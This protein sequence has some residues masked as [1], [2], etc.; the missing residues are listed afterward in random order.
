MP[1]WRRQR[2]GLTL[3]EAIL[4]TALLGTILVSALLTTGRLRR[5]RWFAERR[6]E[7][8]EIADR[9]LAGWWADRD[10]FPRAASGE[11][12]DRPGWR[13][14]TSVRPSEPADRL[15]AEIVTLEVFPPRP[16]GPGDRT[17][18]AVRVEVVLPRPIEGAPSS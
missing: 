15:N 4:A 17:G 9:L 18:P 6:I 16:Q 7:A 13:W 2:P 8:A 5:Q 12:A 1:S 14:R 3:V 10:E 11:V